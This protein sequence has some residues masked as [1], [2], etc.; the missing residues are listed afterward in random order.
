MTLRKAVVVGLD[1]LDSS[2]VERMVERGELP[3]LGRLRQSGGYA[4]LATTLPP[5][6]P[7]AWS[8]FAVGGN[9]GVHGIFDFLHRD[10]ATYRPEIGLYR[11]EQKSRFLPPRAVNLRGGKPVW[12]WLTEAGMSSAVLRHPCTYPPDAPRGRMLAGVGVPDVR[13]GFGSPSYYADQPVK[14]NGD[15]EHVVELAPDGQGR[16][17]LPLRGPHGPNGDAVLELRL[18]VDVAGR[19]VVIT[20][21]GAEPIHLAEGEWSAWLPVRFRLGMLQSVRGLVRFHLVSASPLRLHASPINFDPDSPVFPISHP[22]D[23]ASEL[24]RRLG[25]YHTLGMA[26][27]HTAL[28]NGRISEE[29]FLRQT[30]GVLAERRAMMH[31]ELERLDEGLFYVLYDTSDRIQHMFWRY[32]DPA[33]PAHGAEP[34]SDEY[35]HVIE[36][37]YRACDAIVGEALEYADDE[38]LFMVASDHGFTNFRRALNLNTWLYRNGYL[39]LKDGIEPGEA[40]G[41]LFEHVDW[42]RTRAYGLGM[43]GIYLNLRGREAEGIVNPAESGAEKDELA[44]RLTGLRDPADGTVVVR[45]VYTRSSAYSG[46]H[47]ER[48]PDMV[49][50]C[51]PP[52]RVSSSSA[53]GGV[54]AELVE[55]N[56]ERWSGDHVVDP[57][58]VPGVLFMNRPIA[59]QAPKIID[60]APTILRALGVPGGESME[61]ES[62]IP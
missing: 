46:E 62:L 50:G 58:A 16:T 6:T 53:V 54:P 15:A 52:Y 9:P 23:Y 2:I 56:R 41:D 22:W 18:A 43:A 37:H 4:R 24:N 17:V 8:S 13:G 45:R 14:P 19:R 36:D 55:D 42:S 57:A 28:N 31:Y 39:A 10:P 47:L 1:G 20:G 48:S 34:M 11:Y 29:A 51:A 32:R 27:E 61:G 44:R 21:D 35:T 7:V 59:S 5:Q 33:H 38:T 30:E 25:P 60:L 49:V 40:A 12:A 3:N 26:E